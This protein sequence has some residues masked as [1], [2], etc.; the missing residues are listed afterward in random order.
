MYPPPAQMP[1]A[2]DR[3]TAGSRVGLERG[4]GGADVAGLALRVLELARLAV[5]LAE[6]PVVEG[7]R[8]ESPLRQSPR[9]VARWPAP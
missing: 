4:H 9:V 6:R 1:T 5:A 7:E 8:G 3:Q 2:I